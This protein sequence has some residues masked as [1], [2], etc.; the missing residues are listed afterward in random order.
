MLPP[1]NTLPLA[2]HNHAHVNWMHSYTAGG[3]G[4]GAA[5]RLDQNLVITVDMS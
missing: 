4:R 3:G 5:K 1:A 2:T